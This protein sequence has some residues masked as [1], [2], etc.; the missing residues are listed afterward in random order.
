MAQN[1]FLKLAGQKTG[2]VKGSVT[3]KGEEGRILVIAVSHEIVSPRDPQSG[4]PTGR[5]MHKP[6]V[7]TKETDKSSP[8]LWN[9][10]C[11]NER[12][13]EWSLQFWA[14]GADGKL[15]Q[16]HT[17]QLVNASISDITYRMPNIKNP[18]LVRYAEYEE[19]SFTYQ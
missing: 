6:L 16:S 5:R 9:M 4:L 7:I 3:Q 15:I 2:E 1:A 11:T 13:T 12:I 19:I 18:E 17:V 10:L 14:A 8:L